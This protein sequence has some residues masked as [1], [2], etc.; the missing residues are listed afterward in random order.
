MSQPKIEEILQRGIYG[1]P[2]TLPEE[3]KLF[4]GTISERVYLALTNKQVRKK[5]IYSEA[6]EIMKKHKGIRLYINGDLNY[7]AYSNYVHAA[8]QH[9]IPFTIVNDG[10]D[11]PLGIVIAVETGISNVEDIFIKDKE[12]H[13]D[14]SE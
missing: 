3:R 11:T 6:Q 14:I 2:E 5:G 13:Q 1:T 12:F 10:R 9:S 8:N 4:L 7:P